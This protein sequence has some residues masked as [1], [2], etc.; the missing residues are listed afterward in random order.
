MEIG[1]YIRTKD[2]I[3]DKVIIN[4]NGHCNNPNC[5]YKHVSCEHNYYDEEDIVKSNPNIID[6][7]QIGDYVNGYKIVGIGE[8]T[9]GL[10][11]G[12]KVIDYHSEKVGGLCYFKNEDIK[13]IVT[14]EQFESM[15][16]RIGE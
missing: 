12:T 16:Y 11:V 9:N 13:S 14:R 2:G 1:D 5:N 3:I 8:I 4:Y 10:E 15:E 6:L 7:I